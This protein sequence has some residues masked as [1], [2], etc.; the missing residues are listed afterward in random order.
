MIAAARTSTDLV[1]EVRKLGGGRSR[2]R[3]PVRPTSHERD[4]HRRG[5]TETPEKLTFQYAH[6]GLVPLGYAPPRRAGESSG[7]SPPLRV[8]RRGRGGGRLGAGMSGGPL[9]DPNAQLAEGGAQGGA[10]V[11]ELVADGDGSAGADPAHDEADVFE[12]G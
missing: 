4:R 7:H 2:G 1:P 9:F 6:P 11:A 3:R 5:L 10:D 8:N 12:F